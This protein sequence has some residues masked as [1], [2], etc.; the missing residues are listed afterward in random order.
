MEGNLAGNFPSSRLL[1]VLLSSF[2]SLSL[3]KMN[4]Q[5]RSASFL[6]IGKR[7]NLRKNRIPRKEEREGERKRKKKERIESKKNGMC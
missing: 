3:K 7:C 5:T 2:L 6:L 1:L 4:D